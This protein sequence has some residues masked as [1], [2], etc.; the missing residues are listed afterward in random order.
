[1]P[2]NMSAE[3]RRRWCGALA[4][5]ALAWTAPAYAAAPADGQGG[6]VS[7]YGDPGAPDIS[8]LWLGTLTGIPGQQ[9]GPNRGPVDGRPPTFW[10][11]YPLPY[12]PAYQAIQDARVAAAKR[13]VQLGDVSARCLPFG[14][15][16]MLVSKVYPD[17]I[18][19][20]PGQVTF[21]M[22]NTVPVIVW[23]DGRPHPKDLQP[24]YNGDSIGQWVGDTLFVDT[25][26]LLGS[27]PMD[28]FR[29]PHS[30]KLHIRWSVRRVAADTLHLTA[31]LYDEDAF[32][33]PV[34]TT[35]I[36]R[37]KSGPKWEVLDDASCFE[38]NANRTDNVPAGGFV[39]F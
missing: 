7:F 9:F 31:T 37:A 29:N 34:T 1:M 28:V 4:A 21:F 32:T 25:V 36:W 20:T 38:N 8:G 19:Q 3:V 18:V 5:L 39:K 16:M 14:L 13:G 2:R 11:P 26:G 22:N 10:A 6:P 15:P 23:T 33:E 24:S 35:N 17:E 12:T 27:T 30:A